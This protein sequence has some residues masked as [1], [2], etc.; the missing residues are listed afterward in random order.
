MVTLDGG[1]ERLIRILRSVPKTPPSHRSATTKEMQAVWKWSLAF[2]CVINIGVRGSENVR[3][4]VVE[5]GMVPVT[6]KVLESYLQM[7]EHVK[8]ERRRQEA[9]AGGHSGHMAH[10]A[11]QIVA[12]SATAVAVPAPARSSASRRQSTHRSSRLLASSSQAE[13]EEEE[14]QQPPSS[15][16]AY[17][18]N[19]ESDS[20]PVVLG[21]ASETRP[22]TPAEA[23]SVMTNMGSSSHHHTEYLHASSS[24]H[25]HPDDTARGVMPI[26]NVLESMPLDTTPVGIPDGMLEN[27]SS[28]HSAVSPATSSSSVMPVLPAAVRLQEGMESEASSSRQHR[29]PGMASGHGTL[30][31]VS[32][33]EDLRSGDASGSGSEG[34]GADED[35]DMDPCD[36]DDAMDGVQDDA[37]E[38]E[39]RR[40]PRPTRRALAP[41]T[42]NEPPL[43]WS[44]WHRTVSPSRQ[45]TVVP[46]NS[47]APNIYRTGASSSSS[48]RRGLQA[49]PTARPH[50]SD[51]HRPN[52]APSSSRSHP[53]ASSQANAAPPAHNHHQTI[54]RHHRGGNERMQQQP[55]AVPTT[56]SADMIYREEEVLLSLQLLAY[57]SKYAH[58][59]ALFHD[60]DMVDQAIPISLDGYAPSRSNVS[61]DPNATPKR[62]VFSVAERFTLR[63]S[64]PSTIKLAPEIQYWAGVIMRNACR[65][66]ENRGGIR[67]CAN[68]LCGKWESY[69]RE[70][71][72]CRRCR[73]AKYC[74]KACQSKGWQMGHRFWC[75]ARSEHETSGSHRHG[76]DGTVDPNGFDATRTPGEGDAAHAAGS[77]HHHDRSHHHHHHHHRGM[78]AG[79]APAE[80]LAARAERRRE[81]SNGSRRT[82]LGDV[83]GSDAEDEEMES[84]RRH[85]TLPTHRTDL[86]MPNMPAPVIANQDGHAT[87][88]EFGRG[89]PDEVVHEPMADFDHFLWGTGPQTAPAPPVQVQVHPPH[90]HTHAVGPADH[91]RGPFANA[92]QT[93]HQ[94][95]REHHQQQPL[96]QTAPVAPLGPFGR[97]TEATAPRAGAAAG[98]GADAGAG[99]G[100]GMAMGSDLPPDFDFGTFGARAHARPRGFGQADEQTRQIRQAHPTLAPFS[101][102]QAQLQTQTHNQNPARAQA[103]SL[104]T[105][106]LTPFFQNL[107]VQARQRSQDEGVV[108]AAHGAAAQLGHGF[109]GA[110]GSA[111]G[112]GFGAGAGAGVGFAASAGGGHRTFVDAAVN[113]A[114]QGVISD[115]GSGGAAGAGAADGAT[116]MG[117]GEAFEA[118]GEASVDG[119]TELD[120]EGDAEGEGEGE[121][122]SPAPALAQ[123]DR[124]VGAFFA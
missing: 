98:A 91:A 97:T 77:R 36:V 9:L 104:G 78:P 61:W 23:A 5:A 21:A 103:A 10:E 110:S 40:T 81:S 38:A 32:S 73:K 109:G 34:F 22:T 119:D 69:P 88:V 18:S 24:H 63:S 44:D 1:L 3:T 102:E 107:L 93:M 37:D 60:S 17:A 96:W 120:G 54:G 75:S 47:T 99:A 46:S 121:T 70:F 62:N 105:R 64:K 89:T 33:A 58:V 94:P 72:K 6:I 100:A 76:E 12:A 53:T 113:A 7:L 20:A 4:R 108:G 68:M 79:T 45:E 29:F 124:N 74:S 59:R 35:A 16:T 39:D 90:P 87:G 101:N 8:A 57:L 86:P 30:T 31:A 14:A 25:H 51:P 49:P 106:V 123:V 71:A 112:S 42:A 82:S 65:K 111:S 115:S 28:P 41:L 2:Q 83:D 26:L 27:A 66:D 56:L 19:D 15:S 50:S 114:M 84:A 55:A 52:Y 67:Q 92:A 80:S 43:P 13:E 11:A 122:E 118:D 95:R 117:D 85:M 116:I 48:S